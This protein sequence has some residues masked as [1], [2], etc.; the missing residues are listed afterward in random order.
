V[1]DQKLNSEIERD[2]ESAL[3]RKAS[4]RRSTQHGVSDSVLC[5]AR[6]PLTSLPQLPIYEGL[7]DR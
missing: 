7:V 6:T 4:N 5:P 2:I 1:F 3:V